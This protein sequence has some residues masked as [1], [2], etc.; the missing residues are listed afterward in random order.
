[1]H[2]AFKRFNHDTLGVCIDGLYSSGYDTGHQ[3]FK[4]G[5][6]LWGSDMIYLGYHWIQG[7]SATL[8]ASVLLC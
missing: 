5:G 2:T 8:S 3:G 7:R 6:F 1:M 4:S